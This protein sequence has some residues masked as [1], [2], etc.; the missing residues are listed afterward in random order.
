MVNSRQQNAKLGIGGGKHPKT[1]F[2]ELFNAK[3]LGSL[4]EEGVL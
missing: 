3:L 1:Q 4:V 2:A